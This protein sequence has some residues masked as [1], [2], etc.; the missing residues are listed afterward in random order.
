MIQLNW[1]LPTASWQPFMSEGQQL[2]LGVSTS[3]VH[4]NVPGLCL[5]STPSDIHWPIPGVVLDDNGMS[6]VILYHI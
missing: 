3:I 2:A 6:T 5:G 4:Y 1:S